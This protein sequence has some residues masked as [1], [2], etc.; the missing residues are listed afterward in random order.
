MSVNLKCVVGRAIEDMP[1]NASAVR[2]SNWS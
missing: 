1:D 2:W